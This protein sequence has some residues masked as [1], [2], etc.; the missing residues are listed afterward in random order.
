MSSPEQLP[1]DFAPR[2]AKAL[3]RPGQVNRV[4]SYLEEF[5]SITPLDALR[6]L[7]IM[8]LGARIWELK[9]NLPT[10]TTI[11]SDLVPIPNR[12]GQV[13]HV[14]RYSL[15]TPNKTKIDGTLINPS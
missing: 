1:L 14:A 10:G 9:R 4:L 3:A 15:T 8:R 7:S 6:D 2:Q 11:S 5:G 13:S 12:W